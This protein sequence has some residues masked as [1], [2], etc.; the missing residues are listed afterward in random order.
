[1]R[2]RNDGESDES[3]VFSPRI[4]VTLG[5]RTCSGCVF[6][7]GPTFFLGRADVCSFVRTDLAAFVSFVDVTFFV[8]TVL[9]VP[10]CGSGSLDVPG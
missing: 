8:S 6:D 2:F 7:L 3:G 4:C 10:G 9:E 1:M 5:G